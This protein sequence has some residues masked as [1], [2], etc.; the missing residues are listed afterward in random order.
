MFLY[1][2]SQ[3]EVRKEMVMLERVL[4]E[5]DDSNQLGMKYYPRESINVIDWR[6]KDFRTEVLINSYR[7]MQESQMAAEAFL[8]LRTYFWKSRI[9]SYGQFAPSNGLGNRFY[10]VCELRTY[11]K[12]W[13]P[14]YLNILVAR[15]L[16]MFVGRVTSIGTKLG[17]E[18]NAR[19]V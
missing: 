17:F 19:L 13:T 9:Y 2:R 18:N 10:L 8:N 7:T 15:Q 11:N 16:N 1:F 12:S 4:P 3:Y 5:S 14:S 6:T